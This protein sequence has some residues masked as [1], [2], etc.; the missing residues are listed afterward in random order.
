MLKYVMKATEPDKEELGRLFLNLDLI[1]NNKERIMADADM[2]N[3]LIRGVAIEGLYVGRTPITLGGL[4]TLWE[5]N[6]WREENSFFYHAGG[7]PLSGMCIV[8]IWQADKKKY[9]V[10]RHRSFSKICSTAM[11]ILH[12]LP[13]A[14]PTP[15]NMQTLIQK[16][17]ATGNE[18]EQS[19]GTSN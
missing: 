3:I 13:E 4:L 15:L 1:L 16:L 8:D 5:Q 11:E 17:N 12:R 10:D 19:C 14:Q 7:S 2:R 9:I 18:G 6:G